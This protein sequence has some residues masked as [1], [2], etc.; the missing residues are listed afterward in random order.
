METLHWENHNSNQLNIFIR[1]L[2]LHLN[3]NLKLSKRYVKLNQQNQ[4][5]FLEILYQ[6]LNLL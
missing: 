2:S 5:F 1:D 4:Y 3:A 6:I